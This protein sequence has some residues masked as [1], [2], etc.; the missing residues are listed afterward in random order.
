LE[1]IGFGDNEIKAK[2]QKEDIDGKILLSLQMEDLKEFGT[3]SLGKRKKLLEE[4]AQL[5]TKNAITAPNWSFQQ[6]FIELN[7]WRVVTNGV[8]EFKSFLIK[9]D[10]RI[11]HDQE[12]DALVHFLSLLKGPS[13]PIKEAYAIYNKRLLEN[14]SYYLFSLQDRWRTSAG[15]FKKDDWKEDHKE[16][17][18]WLLER[19]HKQA[20][21]FQWNSK[22]TEL[23]PSVFGMCHGTS[24]DVVWNICQNGFT[25]VSTIDQGW[26]G[27]GVY[28]TSSKEYAYAYSK[29]SP[30]VMILALVIPGNIYP[31]IEHP[32]KDESYMGAACRSGYQAHGTIV[33]GSTKEFGYP[34]N[35]GWT[36]KKYDELVVFQDAQAIPKYV[37]YFD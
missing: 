31:V 21:R 10:D 18:E 9:K 37:I 36:E 3:L 34:I 15:V 25:T 5:K 19:F 24:L 33:S 28:F 6:T 11:F 13:L 12:Y 35:K 20:Q 23:T 26:Y 8:L 4:V 27:K 32:Q 17:R 29:S 22:T 16:S 2:F 14:F 1:S 7:G 30:K